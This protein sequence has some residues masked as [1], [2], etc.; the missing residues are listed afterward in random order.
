MKLITGLSEGML[1]LSILA[2]VG[3]A[4]KA[5]RPQFPRDISGGSPSS[6]GGSSN[7]GSDQSSQYLTIMKV[8]IE[9]N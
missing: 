4:Q 2:K 7:W 5:R 8:S 3:G 1:I 9:I 6:G